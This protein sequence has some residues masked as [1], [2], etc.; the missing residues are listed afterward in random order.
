M[1]SL[2]NFPALRKRAMNTTERSA[3]A[4]I[5]SSS[6]SSVAGH[7]DLCPLRARELLVLG[8]LALAAYSV[9]FLITIRYRDYWGLVWSS[10]DNAGYI[11]IAQGLRFWSAGLIGQVKLFWGT[12]YAI[13]ALASITGLNFGAALLSISIVSCTLG[14]VLCYRLY[15]LGVA[16]W[17]VFISPPMMYR[18]MAGGPE[19]LF[20]ALFLGSLVALRKGSPKTA[21]LLAAL[22]VTVRPIGIFLV[23]AIAVKAIAART[24]VR[25]VQ[26]IGIA[27]IICI[28]YCLPLLLLFKEAFGNVKGYSA[29]W[30]A[31]S[32][33]ISLPLVPIIHQALV[34]KEP[35]SNTIRLGIWVAAVFVILVY[36]GIFQRKVLLYW[37]EH[38][39]E[40]LANV[41]IVI[42]CFSYNSF[43]AWG[44]FPRFVI[45]AI[46]F[47]LALIG[48]ESLCKRTVLYVAAPVCG[49]VSAAYIVGFQQLIHSAQT[50]LGK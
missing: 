32:L 43:W 21:M 28:L 36:K 35:M 40:A 11:H 4:A 23:I 42:F 47:L 48:T 33:P 1:N 13:L 3:T 9:C 16:A 49:A 20:V 46:P 38:P 25:L 41:L 17:F 50:L 14:I 6:I 24:W 45:P 2:G 31:T 29:D 30:Y 12:G 5:P 37:R 19:S 15:G 22:S 26:A 27:G 44:E 39:E 34:S 7:D 10:G 18:S 8:L